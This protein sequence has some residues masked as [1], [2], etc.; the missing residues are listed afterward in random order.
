MTYPPA[1]PPFRGLNVPKPAFTFPQ[2][3]PEADLAP[4]HEIM[5]QLTRQFATLPPLKEDTMPRTPRHMH[6]DPDGD[7]LSIT[8]AYTG[9]NGAY[10]RTE[11]VGGDTVGV[12]VS[13][14]AAP[15]VALAI[16]EAS[17]WTTGPH[18][19]AQA[20]SLLKEGVT[21]SKERAKVAEQIEAE[22]LKLCNA[23][24]QSGYTAFPND[25]MK[26]TW[27]RA[28]RRARELHAPKPVSATESMPKSGRG[29]VKYERTNANGSVD[30]GYGI[31]DYSNG[32][33][34]PFGNNLNTASTAFRDGG[35]SYIFD[36]NRNYKVVK[37]LT[38][39]VAAPKPEPKP[40]PKPRFGLV[41][42]R[43]RLG[44]SVGGVGYGIVDRTRNEIAP[45]GTS[46]EAAA[47]GLA[48]NPRHFTYSPLSRY[49]ITKE[50]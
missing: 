33:V 3:F 21:A 34:A 44:S 47:K 27:V 25:S 6:T 46:R 38:A 17:G 9:S 5:R 20:V 15:A 28:A 18:G 12:Y 29:L 48:D 40:L 22:A 4:F 31:I 8:S 35:N 16:L 24:T 43:R 10:L 26:R 42:Y 2:I 39:T 50:L 32:K 7:L 49:Q 14:D 1:V 41:E 36:T 19:Y 11:E 37:D 23:A 30:T 13:K 45:F